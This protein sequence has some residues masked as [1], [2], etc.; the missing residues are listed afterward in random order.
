MFLFVFCLDSRFHGN[1][2]EINKTPGE[3]GGLLTALKLCCQT[4][5]FKD[6]LSN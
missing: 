3:P 2:E 1:D 5:Q 4:V 6:L